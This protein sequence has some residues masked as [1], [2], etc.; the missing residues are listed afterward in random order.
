ME[1]Q[2][3]CIE[4][5][6]DRFRSTF[7]RVLRT[8]VPLAD[9][10]IRYFLDR[11]GKQLRPILTILSAKM[12]RGEVTEETIFGAVAVELLH[13]ASLMHDDVVDDSPERRGAATINRVWDNRVAVLTGDFFLAK[14]LMCSNAAGSMAISR[15]LGEMVTSLVEGELEQLS[16]ARSH[17]LS[18]D[19][20]F[21]VIRGKTASL[22]AACLRIGAHSVG[23]SEDEVKKMGEIGERIG[24]V[25]QIRDDIFDYFPSND[26]VGKPTGHD[27]MEG[28]VTLPLL[29]ALQQAPA[30]QSKRIKEILLSNREMTETEVSQLVDFAKQMGG[31]E[32]AQ[33]RMKNIAFEAKQLLNSFPTT[34]CLKAFVQIVDYFIDRNY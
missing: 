1:L 31:I 30:E 8:R 16:N 33:A 3:Q 25:F 7:E 11:R 32:Y 21:S 19:A 9:N 20:Y 10:V 14:C 34:D 4:N 24:L 18:E 13:N 23:A 28:K 6:M 22:F 27:I 2:L 5:E 12:L 17:L 29:Y 15:I 26:S